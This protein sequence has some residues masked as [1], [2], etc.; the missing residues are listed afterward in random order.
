MIHKPKIRCAACGK[1]G[2]HFRLRGSK[3]YH[4]PACTTVSIRDTAKSTFPFTT[5]HID[6]HGQPIEVRSMRH[7]RQL[8]NQYGVTSHVYNNNVGEKPD[9]RPDGR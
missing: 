8:E 4:V 3:W 7:L 9:W 5:T 6:P 2:G 1:M